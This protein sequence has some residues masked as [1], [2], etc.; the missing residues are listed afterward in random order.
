[1][2]KL[3]I[4][5]IAV[6]A[7]CGEPALAA[8]MPVKARPMLP[9]AAP[10]YNWTGCYIGANGGYGW[11]NNRSTYSN[12]P[13]APNG[14]PI[15]FVP[16]PSTFHF[17]LQYISTPTGTSGSGGLAGG[18]AGCNWQS[19]QWVL[20]IEGDIDWAGISGSRTNTAFSGPNAQFGLGPGVYS[21]LNSTG[22]AYE[23]L[24]VQWL[25]TIRAR[26]GMAVQ[27]RLLL[28]VT[29]GLA[30]GGVN[31]QGSVNAGVPGVS[32]TTWSGSDSATKTGYAVGAGAEWAFS[33][34]W[35]A[36]A[37]YLWYDLGSMSHPLN[38][39]YNSGFSC[40]ALYPTLGNVSSTAHGSI[41]RAGI[42][43]RFGGPVVAKY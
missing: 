3:F 12:D 9:V 25:S 33:D 37:E 42:N 30:V 10:A 24:S 13:N 6:A 38:C 21:F 16:D 4:A 32:L 14:D 11:N 40:A 41:V 22:T 27:D 7:F 29:G 23:R 43:Y 28:Y 8:D 18:G 19:Q 35:T 2:R 15:N 39:T 20:G 26:A 34:H 36:K 31:S 17:P 1:M 5:S